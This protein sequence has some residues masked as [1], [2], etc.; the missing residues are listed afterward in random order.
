MVNK[1]PAWQRVKL[2]TINDNVFKYEKLEQLGVFNK[3]LEFV[4]IDSK[5]LIDDPE[6]VFLK[7]K[8]LGVYI[9]HGAGLKYEII[10]GYD[11]VFE[12]NKPIKFKCYLNVYKNLFMY[13]LISGI[14]ERCIYDVAFHLEFDS[15]ECAEQ[16]A[17]EI[18]HLYAL[19][20]VPILLGDK[21]PMEW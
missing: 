15:K 11:I 17:N 8:D 16:K 18:E 1:Y 2:M 20:G 5:K 21:L 19:Y 14:K 3:K 7:E 10:N 13:N 9:A 12:R 4:M 6:G